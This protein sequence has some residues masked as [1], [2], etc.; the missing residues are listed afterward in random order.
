[1]NIDFCVTPPPKNTTIFLFKW[2]FTTFF[3][4]QVLCVKI[5]AA[6]HIILLVMVYL[7]V[8]MDLMKKLFIVVYIFFLFFLV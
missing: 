4:I 3:W 1:M 6:F 8:Q 2:H 7:I 5:L